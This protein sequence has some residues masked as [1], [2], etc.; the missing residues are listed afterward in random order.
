MLRIEI[1]ATSIGFMYC[2]CVLCKKGFTPLMSIIWIIHWTININSSQAITSVDIEDMDHEI[3]GVQPATKKIG[4]K[5]DLS[6]E[7]QAV[8]I[9]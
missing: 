3:G 5:S 6:V 2:N 9:S 7:T 4:T 1:D 8:G